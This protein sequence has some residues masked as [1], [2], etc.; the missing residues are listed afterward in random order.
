MLDFDLKNTSTYPRARRVLEAYKKYVVSQSKANLTRGR[1]VNGKKQ[2]YKAS[3]KLYGSIKGYVNAKMNRSV[4]GRF[5]G[6]SQMPSLTFEMADYG[7]FVDEGV[8]GSKS[9]YIENINSPNKFRG[10][11]KSVPVGPI[12]AW[13]KRKGISEKLAFIIARSIY[14]KGIKASHFFTKPLEKRNRTMWTAY[15]KAIADDIANNFANKI[16]AQIKKAE[17]NKLLNKK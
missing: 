7:K 1:M 2:S 16:A 6:G 11:K 5:T 14:E 4:K 13:C 15:H 17:Q 12:K 9:N 8:K 10:N 3:S